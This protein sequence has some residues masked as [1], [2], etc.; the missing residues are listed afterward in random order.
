M[1][2]S[3]SNYGTSVCWQKCVTTTTSATST[4][5]MDPYDACGWSMVPLREIVEVIP[6]AL[7]AKARTLG[8]PDGANLIVDDLGNYRIE[9]KDAKVTYKANR[10]REFSPHLNASDMVAKFLEYVGTLG[11]RKGDLMGL[12][13]H[14]F[15]QWLVI[16]AA[17]RDSDPLPPDVVRIEQHPT[18]LAMTKPKCLCCGRFVKRLH[19]EHKFPFC[20]PEHG[21]LY[22]ERRVQPARIAGPVE[23]PAEVSA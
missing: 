2:G 4:S 19:M 17:E 10:V 12:P 16:E 13:L 15:I 20:S 14:L 1:G 6:K 11:V 18:L 21:A 8:L 23:T 9:D 5:T 3:W 7:P 22:V